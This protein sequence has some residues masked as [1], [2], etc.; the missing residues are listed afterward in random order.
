MDGPIAVHLLA[1]VD[2]SADHPLVAQAAALVTDVG[3]F[4]PELQ[5]LRRALGRAAQGEWPDGP[6]RSERVQ[7]LRLRAALRLRHRR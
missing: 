7:L 2:L 6:R 5:P 1:A 4:E 3:A